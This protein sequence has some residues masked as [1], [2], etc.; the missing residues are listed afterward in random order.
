MLRSRA[1]LLGGSDHRIQESRSIASRRV[2]VC[3]YVGT[4]RLDQSGSAQMEWGG[5]W[6]PVDVFERELKFTPLARLE[7]PSTS[8]PQVRSSLTLEE[9]VSLADEDLVQED[10]FDQVRAD[11]ESIEEHTGNEGATFTRWYQR[12]ALLLVPG[13]TSIEQGPPPL[14]QTMKKKRKK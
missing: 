3:V 7:P 6:E 11:D 9:D 2:C 8:V 14:K 4:I 5:G 13:M 10:Y 1:R 12:T